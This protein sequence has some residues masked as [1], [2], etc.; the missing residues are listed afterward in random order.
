MTAETSVAMLRFRNPK[1]RRNSEISIGTFFIACLYFK[2]IMEEKQKFWTPRQKT[3]EC[4][5]FL[6]AL[7]GLEF[8]QAIKGLQVLI[9]K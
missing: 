3:W 5:F 8:S 2:C 9:F 4:F 6:M 1:Y 7:K